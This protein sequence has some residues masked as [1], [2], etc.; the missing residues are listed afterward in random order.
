MEL[1]L[2]GNCD[3]IGI[4][5]YLSSSFSFSAWPCCLPACILCLLE[6]VLI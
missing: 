6:L 4:S 5:V 1:K 3:W 2:P